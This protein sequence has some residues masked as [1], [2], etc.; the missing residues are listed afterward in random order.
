MKKYRYIFILMVSAIITG[1]TVTKEKEFGPV[2]ESGYTLIQA[3]I[4]SLLFGDDE[5]IWPEGAAIGVYGSEQGE[6]E[7]F[8]IK[9][10]GVGLKEAG[11]YGPLVKGNLLAYFP[12][13]QSYIGG[14]SAMPYTLEA[15]QIYQADP[16]GMFE[17]YTPMAFANMEEGR[18]KF[19]YPNG[20]LKVTVESQ[21]AV[22]VKEIKIISS[23]SKLAGLGVFYPD[24]SLGMTESAQNYVLLDC[25]EGVPAVA[26]DGSLNAFYLVIA[27]GTY[28]D[29]QLSVSLEGADTSFS[30][31]I[32]EEV[33][34]KKISASDFSMV[35]VGFRPAGGPDGFV[36]EEV[37]FEE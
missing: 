9:N 6:N 37:E 5:R 11:F 26:Q 35:T 32:S 25:G 17:K 30:C 21:S 19:A 2:D 16:V 36:E 27:P 34:I 23:E 24:G 13:D 1:C 4:E 22:T 8:V 20:L 33:N 15:E 10:A 3:D 31:P 14:A 18:L 29:L 28:D 7:P 12:F